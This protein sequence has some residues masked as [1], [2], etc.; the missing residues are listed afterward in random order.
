MLYQNYSNQRLVN[1]QEK[2][3]TTKFAVFGRIVVQDETNQLKFNFNTTESGI[4]FETCSR[5]KTEI[6]KLLTRK[7]ML[8]IRKLNHADVTKPGRPDFLP[9]QKPCFTSFQRCLTLGDINA[10][11]K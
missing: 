5:S 8:I 10:F 2:L 6:T 7:N 11:K 4:N 3:K 1:C 9:E